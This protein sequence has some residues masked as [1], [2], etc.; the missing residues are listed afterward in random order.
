MSAAG[1][2]G[3]PSKRRGEHHVRRFDVPVD[4][5]L[6]VGRRQ[7]G[8]HLG[9]DAY[10]D[11]PVEGAGRHVFAQGLALDQFHDDVRDLAAVRRGGAE[12]VHAGHVGMGQPGGGTGLRAY[13]VDAGQAARRDRRGGPHDLDRDRPVEDFVVAAPDL[14]HAADAD[15]PHELIA[16]AQRSHRP[17]LP[18][19]FPLPD[20]T[21]GKHRQTRFTCT[22]V[23]CRDDPVRPD[24]R[25]RL[26]PG[27][28]TPA[29]GGLTARQL[30]DSVSRICHELPVVGMDIVEVSPPFDHAEIT[31]MLGNR[32]VLS[33]RRS[34][35]RPALHRDRAATVRGRAVPED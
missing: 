11:V 10:A 31:A 13:V 8:G 2:A 20:R 19:L 14:G 30:L 17:D 27:T 26:A 35:T 15:P 22:A 7:R 16:P 9:T 3:S 1:V 32:V 21:R 18:Q 5:L 34:V 28:G 29:P 25:P 23:R 6:G 12:V 4:Q 33:R 24:V